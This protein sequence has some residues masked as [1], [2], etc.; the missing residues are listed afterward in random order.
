MLF[1][2]CCIIIVIMSHVI[3]YQSMKIDAIDDGIY[4]NNG[5]KL[6]ERS[7]YLMMFG[8]IVLQIYVYAEVFYAFKFKLDLFSASYTIACLVMTAYVFDLF[9]KGRNRTFNLFFLKFSGHKIVTSMVNRDYVN[10]VVYR[11]KMHPQL[12]FNSGNTEAVF[13]LLKDLQSNPDIFLKLSPLSKQRHLK[14]SIFRYSVAWFVTLLMVACI[15][16]IVKNEFYV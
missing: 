4:M 7:F 5:S 11:H 12:Y 14:S 10:D 13:A 3:K 2:L 1:V 6:F 15:V 16:L 8:L 9:K